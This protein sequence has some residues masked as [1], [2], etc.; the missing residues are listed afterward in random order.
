VFE[1]EDIEENDDV[2]VVDFDTE[3]DDE[4][5]EE[6]E[7]LLTE[8]STIVTS[9]VELLEAFDSFHSVTILVAVLYISEI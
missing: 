8:G 5:E 2:F 9:C 7:E 6:E 3:D 4:E 1:I